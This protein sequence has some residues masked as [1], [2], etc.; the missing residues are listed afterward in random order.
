MKNKLNMRQAQKC[1]RKLAKNISNKY[2][3]K[4]ESDTNMN[5]GFGYINDSIEG[6]YSIHF[7][8]NIQTNGIILKEIDTIDFLNIIRALYHEEQHI[9]QNCQAYLE[10]Q[11]SDD[12]ILMSLRKVSSITNRKYYKGNNRYNNDL[13]E[14]EAEIMAIANTYDYIQKQFPKSNADALIC[15]LVNYKIET[16]DYFIK[17]RYNSFDD[18]IDAF[19]NHYEEAKS[20][21]IS[22]YIAYVLRPSQDI[23]TEKD[24]CI[25]YLQACVRENSKNIDLMTQFNSKNE[26][27]QKDLMI[28]SI[29]CKLHPEINYEKIY[30]CLCNVDLSPQNIFDKD[31]PDV[32][33]DIKEEIS[34]EKIDMHIDLT[35]KIHDKILNDEYKTYIKS[36]HTDFQI[37]ESLLNQRHTKEETHD[38]EP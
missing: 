13:S 18:V 26:P 36:N 11:T 1:I 3:I 31:L 16:S 22:G 14:I 8:N 15:N 29:T 20:K 32:T 5:A 4:I 6:D 27:Y 33:E 35:K 17:G 10:K 30:P 7:G 28:A 12:T 23:N 37:N 19:S 2:N 38:F 9:L 25:R 34:K 21:Q 24:E